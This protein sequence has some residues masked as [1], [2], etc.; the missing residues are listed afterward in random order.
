[1]PKKNLRHVQRDPGILG[2]KNNS[3][4]QQ[5]QKLTSTIV[6]NLNTDEVVNCSNKKYRTLQIGVKNSKR[7]I[8]LKKRLNFLTDEDLVTY[9]L[10]LADSITGYV[11][12]IFFI[13][14]H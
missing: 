2:A 11:E 14:F 3:C 12:Q 6:A 1:M 4:Q 7:F 10:D 5:Q 13:G 9:L 8:C